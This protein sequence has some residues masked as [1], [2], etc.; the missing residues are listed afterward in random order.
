M[1]WFTDNQNV[2]RIV[3]VSSRKPAAALQA[4]AVEIFR[5][6]WDNSISLEPEWIPREQNQLADYISRLVDQDDWMLNPDIFRSLDYLWGPH[7]VDRFASGHNAQLQ[8]FN[9]LFWNPGSE[10]V[11]AFTVDWGGEIT[12]DAPPQSV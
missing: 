7:T 3:T 11:D 4:V 6:A 1:K 2:S 9:S 10:A 5:I 8:R 12:G